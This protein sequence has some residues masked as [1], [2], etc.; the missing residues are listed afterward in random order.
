M[1]ELLQWRIGD[2]RITCIPESCQ[3]YPLKNI[4][5]DANADRLEVHRSWL[6]PHFLEGQDGLLISVHGL[7]VESRGKRILVDTCIGPHMP[8]HENSIVFLKN[9]EAAGFSPG[10]IDVVMCTHLHFD[11]VGW[12]TTLIDGQWVPTFPNAR[13]LYARREWDHWNNARDKGFAMT[14][15]ECVSPVMEAGLVD[16]IDMDH[17]ITEEVRLLPTP[18]HTPGH[19]S[20]L[21]DSRGEQAIITG[22]MVFHPVQWAEVNWLTGGDGDRDQAVETRC[23]IR[24]RYADTGVLIIGTHFASPTAGYISKNGDEGYWFKV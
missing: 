6:A 7:L 10:D 11:H 13:Y 2:T 16:L 21:I 8:G 3:S 22:D 17:A 1:I 12:N 14:F 20:V 4:I 9:L 19:V 23:R 24:D 18:G 15:A 5:P